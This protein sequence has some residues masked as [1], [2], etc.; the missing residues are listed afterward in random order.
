MRYWLFVLALFMAES[1]LAQK[2]F[3]Y[4]PPNT[5]LK[6]KKKFQEKLELE[7]AEDIAA[8][9]GKNK[10][11][12]SDIYLNRANYVLTLAD[13]GEFIF[14]TPMNTYAEQVLSN[15]LTAN[16]DIPAER[17]KFFILRDIS[18][19][20]SCLGEGTIFLNIGLMRRLDNES[21]L[22]FVLAHELAHYTGNHVNENITT[23]V[24]YKNSKETQRQ[25]KAITKEKYRRN[26]KGLEMLKGFAYSTSRHSRTS[27]SAADSK[28]LEY[29]AKANYSLEE[30]AKALELLD[31]IDEEKYD[32]KLNLIKTFDRQLYPFQPEWL[33]EENPL[34]VFFGAGKEEEQA[35]EILNKDSL[36]THP[37]ALKRAELARSQ[38]ASFSG[39]GKVSLQ[40]PDLHNYAVD[41]ADFEAVLA[42]YHYDNYGLTIYMALELLEKHPDHPFLTGIIGICMGKMAV[43]IDK[44]ELGKVLPASSPAFDE[45][46]NEVLKFL[47]GLSRKNMYEVGYNYVYVFRD[48]AP[49]SEALTY[50]LALTSRIKGKYKEKEAYKQQYLKNFPSGYFLKEARKV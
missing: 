3:D 50:A 20:A 12:I 32:V 15:L 47:N 42:A 1:V 10:K 38:K 44:K 22:A 17:I 43:A 23:H 6:S 46:Y 7:L 28:A 16:P 14:D 19:N 41:Q 25:I 33:E 35:E 40:S 34:S 24:A 37:D 31:T 36:K 49:E 13:E 5:Y 18:P 21:Q 4:N 26:E 45:G 48:R 29:M 11:E 2:A 9:P 39:A 8:L 30:A 27:E